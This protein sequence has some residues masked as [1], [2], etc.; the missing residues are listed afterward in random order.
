M[1]G[2]GKHACRLPIDR[3]SL[4]ATELK[5]DPCVCSVGATIPQ[6]ISKSA[7]EE[8]PTQQRLQETTRT[9][10]QAATTSDF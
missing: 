6:I 4:L 5:S 10:G 2:R 3:C 7:R 8:K 9:A 1:V